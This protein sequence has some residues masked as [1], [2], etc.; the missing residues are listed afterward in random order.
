MAP[1]NAK[2]D[3]ETGGGGSAE[4]DGGWGCRAEHNPGAETL[5]VAGATSPSGHDTLTQAPRDATSSRSYKRAHKDLQTFYGATDN[6]RSIVG[7]RTSTLGTPAA[8][9]TEKITSSTGRKR[10]GLHWP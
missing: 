3:Y 7:N 8:T 2:R 6:G 10:T 9:A 1:C 5:P 4:Q